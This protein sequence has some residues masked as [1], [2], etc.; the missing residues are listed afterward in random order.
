M[1]HGSSS[2]SDVA[3]HFNPRTPCG[4]RPSARR[5]CIRMI[6]FNPRNPCGVRHRRALLLC[7]PQYFNPR[8]PCG[9]R[10]IS[11]LTGSRTPESFQSTHPMRGATSEVVSRAT[12]HAISIH[13]PHAGCDEIHEATAQFYQFQST[14]PMRGATLTMIDQADGNR[15]SIH[16]PHAGCDAS[17]KLATGLEDDFN[18][19]TP[20]G[21]RQFQSR[22]YQYS[23]RFQSTHPMRGATPLSFA[24]SI[25]VLN[26]NPR[27]PCGVRQ[28]CWPQGRLPSQISIHAPHAGCDE[29]GVRVT[30]SILISIH[31]PHAGCDVKDVQEPTQYKDFNPRTPCGVRPREDIRELKRLEFQSTHPMRGA[32]PTAETRSRRSVFQSTHPMRGATSFPADDVALSVISIHAPHAGCDKIICSLSSLCPDFNPRTP[33]GVRL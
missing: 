30:F 13:A 27:T 31:A 10:L 21:V 29:G 19:R 6:H 4:V 26:F 2:G 9:V 1:R 28:F 23:A 20:C 22:F 7:F 25:F 5:S 18:P 3:E 32:T 16:A 15:I 12:G 11:L 17:V 8:T 33:C 24:I 14:H